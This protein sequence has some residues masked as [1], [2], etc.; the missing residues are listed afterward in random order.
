[1]LANL[2]V[3]AVVFHNPLATPPP[4]DDILLPA[5]NIA[6]TPIAAT[7]TTGD[8]DPALPYRPLGVNIHHSIHSSCSILDYNSAPAAG[9]STLS[10]TSRYNT[11]ARPFDSAQSAQQQQQ[12]Q[13]PQPGGDRIAYE[14][15]FGH[16]AETGSVSARANGAYIPSH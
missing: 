4:D 14:P 7:T 11:N 2:P 13:Q 1:M 9:I 5:L 12:Q 8:L 6:A 10:S 16:S 15:A 3:P